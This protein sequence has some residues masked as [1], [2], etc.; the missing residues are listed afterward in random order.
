[1]CD[2][3]EPPLAHDCP[4]ALNVP[5][6]NAGKAIWQEGF[7][8]EILLKAIP[9]V[10]FWERQTMVELDFNTKLEIR[11]NACDDNVEIHTKTSSSVTVMVKESAVGQMRSEGVYGRFG[12][13]LNGLVGSAP[14][15]Q[16]I[17]VTC[18]AMIPPSPPIKANSLS[19]PCMSQH[20]PAPRPLGAGMIAHTPSD[21]RTPDI[22]MF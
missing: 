4:F 15:A 22:C 13:S 16:D 5:R 3:P 20:T 1:M 8:V 7:Y 12:C 6:Y 19:G 17:H 21:I 10:H 18:R 2:H 14:L 9:S 11:N